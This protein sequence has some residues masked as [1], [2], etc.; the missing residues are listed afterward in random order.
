MARAAIF[1]LAICGFVQIQFLVKLLDILHNYRDGRRLRRFRIR[2]VGFGLVGFVRETTT[3]T[4]L[5]ICCVWPIE[6]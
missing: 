5:Y 1:N 3:I 6:I 4:G 2:S